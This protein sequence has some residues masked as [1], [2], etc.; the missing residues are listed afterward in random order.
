MLLS[1]SF[2]C[3]NSTEYYRVR[4]IGHYLLNA[5]FS[6]TLSELGH[7]FPTLT[8]DL[9][10]LALDAIDSR[11]VRVIFMVRKS[12]ECPDSMKVTFFKSPRFHKCLLDCMA[13]SNFDTP[14]NGELILW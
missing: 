4:A 13:V 7:G 5:M 2:F 10:V 8:P 9:Q 6:L 3:F 1:I 12:M 14:I 11:T